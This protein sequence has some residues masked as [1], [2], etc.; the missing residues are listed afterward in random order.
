MLR[1]GWIRDKMG[2]ELCRRDDEDQATSKLEGY[3]EWSHFGDGWAESSERWS[4]S[5][6]LI[7]EAI[8]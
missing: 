5:S 8:D 4:D 1:D 2:N 6:L 3:F 7:W